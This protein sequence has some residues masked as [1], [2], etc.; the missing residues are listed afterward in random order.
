VDAIKIDIEGFEMHALRGAEKTLRRFRPRLFIEVGYT[1][2]LK[3]GTTPTE[4]IR[5]LEDL[6]YKAYHAETGDRVDTGYDFTPLADGG[7]DVYA[8]P[9]QKT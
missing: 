6:D 8:L 3:H 5:F 4:M 2:L 7:I 9:E 1:R